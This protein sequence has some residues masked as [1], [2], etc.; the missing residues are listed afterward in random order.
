MGREIE[1]AAQ[2]RGHEIVRTF[3]SHNPPRA[4]D[5]KDCDV[6][7]EFSTPGSVVDNILTCFEAGCPVVVGAT[8]W[9]G[10]FD[11]VKNEAL[12]L[13][14]SLLY[15]TNFSIGVNVFFH[16]NKELARIMDK[17]ENYEPS[18][19]EI[20]HVAKL[21]K[22]SGTAITIAEGI[23]NNVSRKDRWVNESEHTSNELSIV[24]ERTGEVP[25]THTV[26]YTSSVDTISMTHQAHN[27][28][29]FAL[30]AVQA[31]EW[32]KHKK[33]VYTMSDFLQF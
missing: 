26:S 30:G 6:A 4:E 25:G 24:S 33:G 21:D 5:L 13:N 10:R 11:E 28:K 29:G 7:I 12:R 22:P 2:E 16:L 19:L 1:L 9:Y 3:G 14:Q 17:L 31:A 20:H 32:I 18:I 8:G 23:L 15:A 27:R